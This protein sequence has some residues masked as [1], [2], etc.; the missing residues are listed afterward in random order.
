LRFPRFIRVREDKNPEDATNAEQV[1]DMY[2]RQ[3]VIQSN[4]AYAND[5]DDEEY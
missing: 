1:A 2:K 5:A 3:Q 4:N